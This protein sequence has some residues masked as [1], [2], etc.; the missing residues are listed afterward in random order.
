MLGSKE[1]KNRPHLS[2]Q[3]IFEGMVIRYFD[4]MK[5][6][7]ELEAELKIAK[8]HETS[9]GSISKRPS[10]L[11]LLKP[12]IQM[13]RRDSPNISPRPTISKKEFG[14]LLKIAVMAAGEDTGNGTSPQKKK[15]IFGKFTFGKDEILASEPKTPDGL[16]PGE[17]SFDFR[18]VIPQRDSEPDLVRFGRAGSNI[19]NA[20]G[21]SITEF[22]AEEQKRKEPEQEQSDHSSKHNLEEQ[23]QPTEGQSQTYSIPKIIELHES[24]QMIDLNLPDAIGIKEK[25]D[26]LSENIMKA[27]EDLIKEISETKNVINQ[28]TSRSEILF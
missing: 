20:S 6:R 1:G 22:G 27:S 24:Q 16:S 19:S 10:S 3:Q 17:G 18:E 11:K 2:T 4:L 21:V 8:E 23:K 25:S 13:S 12:N 26:V 28:I 14:G 7:N 15:S 9:S 5:Q